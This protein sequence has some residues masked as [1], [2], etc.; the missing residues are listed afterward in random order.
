MDGGDLGAER[1]AAEMEAGDGGG[2]NG[3]GGDGGGGDRL[4]E[5]GDRG[6]WCAEMA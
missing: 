4:V 1:V 5:G 2:G 3:G 6:R